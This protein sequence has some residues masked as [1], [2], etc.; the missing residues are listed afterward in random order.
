MSARYA[1]YGVRENKIWVAF[2]F[3]KEGL[4]HNSTIYACQ[5][6][7]HHFIVKKVHG[8]DYGLFNSQAEVVS[9]GSHSLVD[10]L[11]ECEFMLPHNMLP[12]EK[13]KMIYV[14]L[15]SPGRRTSSA[16]PLPPTITIFHDCPDL[17]HI[18][19]ASILLQQLNVVHRR[20]S[21]LRVAMEGFP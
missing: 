4:M 15:T 6:Y 9:K 3:S 8:F 10:G 12:D 11:F 19:K 7:N 14:S 5:R 16:S 17:R 1:R 13:M 20:C 21:S 18:I 2:G